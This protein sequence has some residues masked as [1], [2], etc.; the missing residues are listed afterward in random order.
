MA[1]TARVLSS[2]AVALVTVATLSSCLTQPGGGADTGVGV[3]TVLAD[4]D[5]DAVRVAVIGD[6]ILAPDCYGCSLVNPS[7][8]GAE[9]I[10]PQLDGDP[11]IDLVRYDAVYGTTMLSHSGIAAA[12]ALHPDEMVI[13]LYPNDALQIG[14]GNETLL[15]ARARVT[16][17]ADAARDA[18]VR[19]LNWITYQTAGTHDGVWGLLPVAP[20]MAVQLRDEVRRLADTRSDVA[21]IDFG[22]EV[23]VSIHQGQPVLD[24]RDFVH[25]LP[26]V[27]VMLGQ[28]IRAAV[29]DGRCADDPDESAPTSPATAA[30]PPTG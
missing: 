18:G 23:D 11:H 15:A 22:A 14:D 3:P 16:G 19:C 20:A 21:V 9:E 27:S 2:V 6:S 30:D 1:P 24:P 4:K 26:V 5:P 28:R 12:L 29:R 10:R 25:Y 8:G 17:I 7:L 13:D